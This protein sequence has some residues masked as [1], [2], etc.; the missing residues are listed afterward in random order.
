MKNMNFSSSFLSLAAAAVLLA[1]CGESHGQAP[2]V[3]PLQTVA[4][5][6]ARAQTSGGDLL[7][8]AHEGASNY[9]KHGVISILSYPGGMPVA[10][11]RHIDALGICA[12]PS[13]NVWVIAYVSG[14]FELLEYAHG[15][16]TSIAEITMPKNTYARGCAVDPASGDLAVANERSGNPYGGRIY[17]WAGARPG[18]PAVH[19]APFVTEYVTYDDDGNIFAAGYPG[20][21]DPWLVLGELPKG[22]RELEHIKLDKRTGAPGSIAWDGTRVAVGTGGFVLKGAPR[23]Y[24]VKISGTSGRVTGET[25]PRDPAM[26]V[27][28]IFSLLA[29][30]VVSIAGS[31]GDRVDVWPYPS[32]GTRT[33]YIGF[34][35]RIE[36]MT[37]S[38]G[39]AP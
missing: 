29:G 16:T 7:Y 34:F 25:V 26:Y 18:K 12:D 23:I 15:G 11:I 38:P 27:R 31:A 20:G 37:I 36:G 4:N 33:Q 17:V 24:R 28:P 22:A 9:T 21:S 13:G 14:A 1:G 3:P 19:K 2:G 30:S 35:E 10:R 8:I 39:H 32:G 6:G 5:P